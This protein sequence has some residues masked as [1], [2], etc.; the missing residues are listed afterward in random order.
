M[1]KSAKAKKEKKKDFAKPKLKVGRGKAK[2]DNFTDTSFKAQSISVLHQSLTTSAP[3]LADQFSHQLN[4]IN[5]KSETHRKDSLANLTSTLLSLPKGTPPPQ[6]VGVI[7]QKAQP[8]IRDTSTAVRTQ[9]L[10][11]LQ[12]LPAEEVRGHAERLLLWVQLGMTHLSTPI[13]LSSLDVLEWLLNTAGEE[14]VSCAGGWTKTL[15]CF[16]G[17]LGWDTEPPKIKNGIKGPATMTGSNWTSTPTTAGKGA[18]DLKL[19]T[20]TIQVLTLYLETGLLPSRS[21][22]NLEVL[23]EKNE[24]RAFPICNMEA[25]M[26]PVRSGV[27]DPFGHLNLF[28]APKDE[29]GMAYEGLEERVRFFTTRWRYGFTAGVERVKLEGG[30]V[31]RAAIVVDRVM[32]KALAI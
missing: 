14:A 10:K 26:L 6:P 18:G 21:A 24:R 23:D 12:A 3:S 5:H 8:L 32:Q 19:L 9:L 31:G 20:R 4:N 2:P 11:L 15:K 25:H 28:G 17:L 30:G 22:T 7:L 16:A 13:R 1:G 27:I 29:E